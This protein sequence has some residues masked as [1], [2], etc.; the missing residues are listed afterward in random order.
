MNKNKITKI[1]KEHLEDG[2]TECR[3]CLRCYSFIW[4]INSYSKER[5]VCP[6]I[7]VAQELVLFVGNG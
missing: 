2:E 1:I 4:P 6:K 7:L 3:L 5:A